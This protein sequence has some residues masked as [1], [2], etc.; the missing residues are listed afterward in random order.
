M[1]KPGKNM[2]ATL[3]GNSAYIFLIRLFPALAAFI[4]LILFSRHMPPEF[5]GKYQT[6]WVQWQVLNTLAC[7]GLP[8][9]IFTYPLAHITGLIRSL[10]LK[11]KFLLIACQMLCAI[12]FAWLQMHSGK[13]L[14]PPVPCAL[15]LLCSALTALAE[16]Y[17][18]PARIFRYVAL[19]SGAYAMV[20]IA[21]HWLFIRQQINT[22]GLLLTLLLAG[23]VRLLLLLVK[24]RLVY[25]STIKDAPLVTL[26]SIR[27]LWFHLGV[28]D[29]VQMLFRWIDKLI[30]GFLL[31]APAFALYFNGTIDIPFLPLLLG[32]AGSAL[33]MQLNNQEAEDSARTAL[34]KESGS[35]LSRIVFPVF[36]FLILFRYEL[37][38]VVFRHRYDTAVSLFLISAMVV[39]LRAYNFTSM[40]QYKGKGRIINAGAL[41]DLAVALVL[42]YPLYRFFSLNGIAFAF[43]LSTWLQ[44]GFYLRHTAKMLGVSWHQLLPWK[45]WLSQLIVF[46]V[47]LIGLYYTL[48]HYLN[49]A[50]VLFLGAGALAVMILLALL[51]VLL[52]KRISKHG[53]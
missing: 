22:E 6:F 31:A 12:A 32:A 35:L 51:P 40:L 17:L 9:L 19:V 52:N 44:A 8:A 41:L 24:A 25:Q 11:R 27:S 42:M 37:F 2:S 29:V 3:L 5:Y 49:D 16:A 30:L 38:G 47:V 39:P 28:Y 45:A 34:L 13:G 14:F 53:Q 43:V 21:A 50:A 33:L 48:A 36:L 26:H 15:F 7:L 18:L 1:H 23:A 10:F 20:F 4:A 46:S